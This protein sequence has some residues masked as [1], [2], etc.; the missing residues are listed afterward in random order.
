MPPR[1]EHFPLDRAA[2]YEKLA[3]LQGAKKAAKDAADL[4]AEAAIDQKIL[5]HQKRKPQCHAP[6]HSSSSHS[7]S[8][9]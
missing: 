1:V 7:L 5:D 6:P 4:A 8:P 9:P 2:Y 3:S